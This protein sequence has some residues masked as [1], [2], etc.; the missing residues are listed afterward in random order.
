MENETKQEAQAPMN[1]K[2][3]ISVA[4]KE[5]GIHQKL[6]SIEEKLVLLGPKKDEKKKFF[7]MPLFWG[8]KEKKINKSFNKVQWILLGNN[9][10]ISP[11]VKEIK[12]GFVEHNQKFYDASAG[13]IYRWRGKTPTLVQPEW[14]ITPIGPKDY[15]IAVEK[16]MGSI[17]AQK[18][19]IRAMEAAKLEDKTGPGK[20]TWVIGGIALLVLGY[21]LFGSG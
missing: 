3:P 11:L 9:E 13:F 20:M 12:N 4:P 17:E 1:E 21:V 19:I 5:G 7:K 10:N 8:A 15:E 14:R 2:E 16:G 6:T 18:I